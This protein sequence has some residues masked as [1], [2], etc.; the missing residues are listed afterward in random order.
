[1]N[2]VCPGSTVLLSMA[3]SLLEDGRS[4]LGGMPPSR[5]PEYGMPTLHGQAVFDRLFILHGIGY[6]EAR[7]E[8]LV[9]LRYWQFG[10][11]GGHSGL[12]V[13]VAALVGRSIAR[14]L[15]YEPKWPRFSCMR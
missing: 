1:M 5:G 10:P 2:G 3:R 4:S 8:I 7:L 11:N 9:S 14:W 15:C 13:T 12:R 6:R